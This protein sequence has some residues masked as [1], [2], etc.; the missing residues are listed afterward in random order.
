MTTNAI[1]IQMP[2]GRGLLTR[3]AKDAW[4]IDEVLVHLTAEQAARSTRWPVPRGA[5]TDRGALVALLSG[6]GALDPYL[7][8]GPD[9]PARWDVAQIAEEWL[10]RGAPL[11]WYE[12]APHAAPAAIPCPPSTGESASYFG[13][14]D[15]SVRDAE[16][17]RQDTVRTV[18]AAVRQRAASQRGGWV[19]PTPEEAAAVEAAH[20]A[21]EAARRPAAPLTPAALTRTGSAT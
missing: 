12:T 18:G 20:W 16:M 8:S 21:V 3:R 15:P 1:R 19:E 4:Q 2:G 13:S 17:R 14:G 10:R 11:T 9:E 7:L 5:Q 6:T